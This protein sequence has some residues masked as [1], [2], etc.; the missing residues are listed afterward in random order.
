VKKKI[1]LWAVA[2]ATTAAVASVGAGG[3]VYASTVT[4]SPAGYA[5]PTIVLVHGAFAD[6]SSWSNE[7]T[8][9]R[10]DGY[11]VV[12]IGNPLRGLPSDTAYVTSVLA[13]I[14]GPVVLVGH[15]YA[16]M[17]ISQAAASAPNVKA[18]VYVAGFIPQ[19][20]ESAGALNVKFPGSQLVADNFVIRPQPDG[21]DI[22]L[23]QDKYGQVYAGGL[24]AADIR[25]A[26]V[27]QRP[28]TLAALTDPATAAAPADL[29]KWMV[30]AT[31]DHAVPTPLQYFMAQRAS[32]HVIT[33]RSGHDVPAAQPQIV[34]RAIIAAASTVH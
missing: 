10:E 33:A 19:V 32:A 11:P 15:S 13:T 21:T 31:D 14:D 22:Y 30:V 6:S 16:G 8:E 20:G 23:R 3:A 7:I 29:P 27:T 25:V 1:R 12:A 34:D 2:L 9:L 28:I 24:S 18:L 5:K 17:V 4:Q 26:S